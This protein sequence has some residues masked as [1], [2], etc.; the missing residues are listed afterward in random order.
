MVGVPRHASGTEGDAG[1]P[2][3][4]VEFGTVRR[5][6]ASS[7][8]TVGFLPSEGASRS[9]KPICAS[10]MR[11]GPDS[12][13]RASAPGSLSA[14]VELVQDASDDSG[15]CAGDRGVVDKI[16]ERGSVFVR[17]DRGL[18]S[19]STRR[20]RRSSSW[21][22]STCSD[23]QAPPARLARRRM[24]RN[25]IGCGNHV[26]SSNEG[27]LALLPGFLPVG[28]GGRLLGLPR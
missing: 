1:E 22:R 6:G 4:A 20:A 16:D 3:Q 2:I 28:V 14:R 8:S 18:A 17:W 7:P 9:R 19:R 10:A 5:R 13:R 24:A 11:T 21:P 25:C 27:G 15:L 12:S 23:L 26:V